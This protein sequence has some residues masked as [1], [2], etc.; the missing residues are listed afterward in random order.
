[1]K[2]RKHELTLPERQLLKIVPKVLHPKLRE[3]L[4]FFDT[5]PHDLAF[6]WEVGRLLGQLEG[7]Y[8]DDLRQRREIILPLT[9]AEC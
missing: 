5:W 8:G 9:R 7:R 6:F 3:L 1:M 2:S 4:D